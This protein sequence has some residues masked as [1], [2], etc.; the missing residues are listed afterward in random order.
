[1]KTR[2]F[3]TDLASSELRKPVELPNGWL[4]VDAFIA[5]TGILEYVEPD[6]TVRREYRPPEEAFAPATLA[7]FASVPLTLQHPPEGSLTPENTRQHQVGTV[8]QPA[9]DRDK[10]RASILVTDAEAIDE[11]RSGTVQLSCGYVCELEF[12]PGV[13]NGERYDAVQ[14]AVVGNHVALVEAG[15]AGPEI[16]LRADA[17]ARLDARRVG[18]LTADEADE[19]AAVRDFVAQGVAPATAFARVTYQRRLQQHFSGAKKP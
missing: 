10:V 17:A 4:R 5:R 8:E 15:R 11:I 9:R 13:V 14:R 3:R 6:G 12:T 7:S 19:L 1:M 18:S 16:S 2:V